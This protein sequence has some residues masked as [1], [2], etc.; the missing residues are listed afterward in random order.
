MEQPLRSVTPLG[1]VIVAALQDVPQDVPQSSPAS[2]GESP[3]ETLSAAV[4]SEENQPVDAAAGVR[5][6]HPTCC[7][8]VDCSE[9]KGA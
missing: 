1:Q 6:L 2:R 3:Q 7:D 4:V 5:T 9:K 8:G